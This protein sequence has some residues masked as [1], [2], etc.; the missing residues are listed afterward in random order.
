MH[1]LKS[2]TD[3]GERF[4]QVYCNLK[5]K[6]KTISY[7]NTTLIGF[8]LYLTQTNSFLEPI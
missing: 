8:M 4:V 7:K 5:T 3:L 6:T 2:A 1:L